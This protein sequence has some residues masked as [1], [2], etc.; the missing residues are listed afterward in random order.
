MF[1]KIIVP[2]DRLVVIWTNNG[3]TMTSLTFEIAPI[4]KRN[5]EFL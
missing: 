2:D 4:L 5:S 1:D 3:V